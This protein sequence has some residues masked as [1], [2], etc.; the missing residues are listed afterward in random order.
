MWKAFKEPS[1][2]GQIKQAVETFLSKITIPLASFTVVVAIK[3][4]RPGRSPLRIG[5]V[6][7][8]MIGDLVD[9]EI[10]KEVTVE[11]EGKVSTWAH[12]QVTVPSEERLA[13]EVST[14]VEEALDL[15]A[16]LDQRS[17]FFRG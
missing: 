4:L 14:T 8:G 11:S 2:E 3:G 15:L 9:D 6:S 13:D 10:A 12:L 1:K 16:T 17:R 5:D 7:I